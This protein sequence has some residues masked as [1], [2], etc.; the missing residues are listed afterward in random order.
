MSAVIFKLKFKHPNLQTTK[1]K[2][3][4]HVIYIATRSGVDKE[5]ISLDKQLEKEI[6]FSESNKE[7]DDTDYINYIN[8]RPNS[9]GLFDESGEADFVNIKKEIYSHEGYVWRGIVSL[10]ENEAEPLGYL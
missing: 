1:G 5:I 10:R 3:L 4:G 9:H 8:E 7:L 6:D 2:N